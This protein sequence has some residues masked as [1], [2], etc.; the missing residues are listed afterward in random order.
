MAQSAL[1]HSVQIRVNDPLQLAV[2]NSA[3]DAAE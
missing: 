2:T 1:L 3:L